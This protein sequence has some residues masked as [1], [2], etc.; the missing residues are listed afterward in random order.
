MRVDDRLSAE[1]KRNRFRTRGPKRPDSQPEARV[2]PGRPKVRRCT[3]EKF[4]LSTNLIL[5]PIEKELRVR[6]QKMKIKTD[7]E[8]GRDR[9]CFWCRIL[10]RSPSPGPGTTLE[11]ESGRPLLDCG[12]RVSYPPG[13]ARKPPTL[14][15]LP[16]SS[17]L[18]SAARAE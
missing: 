15:S 12:S 5:N 11:G 18:R 6:R 9:K 8:T 13:E 7:T 17:V 14:P 1:R 10:T 3:E 2:S 16:S 4:S